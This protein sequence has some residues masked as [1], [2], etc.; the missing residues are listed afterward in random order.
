LKDGDCRID[1]GVAAGA[2][3]IIVGDQNALVAVLYGDARYADMA[4]ALSV[5]GDQ[6]LADRFATLFHLPP[7]APD[8]VNAP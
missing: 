3:A 1:R 2:D 4:G 7:K 6:A 8:M 5:E